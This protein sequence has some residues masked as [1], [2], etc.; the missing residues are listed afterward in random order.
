MMKSLQE[1]LEDMR[2]QALPMPTYDGPEP[3]EFELYRIS[4]FLGQGRFCEL[5]SVHQTFVCRR[6]IPSLTRYGVYPPP[7]AMSLEVQP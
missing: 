5:N 4:H 1:L 2:F 7:A 6:F 3:S